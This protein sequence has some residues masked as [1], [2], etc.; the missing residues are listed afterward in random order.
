MI[1]FD[2]APLQS[3]QACEPIRRK[4]ATRLLSLPRRCANPSCS[5]TCSLCLPT[6]NQQRQLV[7]AQTSAVAAAAAAACVKVKPHVTKEKTLFEIIEPTS[8][9]TYSSNNQQIDVV[10]QASSSEELTELGKRGVISAIRIGEDVG[11]R[12]KFS[13][14]FD[15]IWSI[16]T[17][18]S[19]SPAYS[20]DQKNRGSFRWQVPV[21]TSGGVWCVELAVVRDDGVRYCSRSD[22]FVI[23]GRISDV[24]YCGGCRATT[25]T[26]LDRRQTFIQCLV[27]AAYWHLQCCNNA[28]TTTATQNNLEELQFECDT[29]R[30]MRFGFELVDENVAALQTF[31]SMLDSDFVGYSIRYVDQLA[32][33]PAAVVGLIVKCVQHACAGDSKGM[34]V[35]V[36]ISTITEIITN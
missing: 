28:T 10:W 35:I 6:I 33:T 19:S 21:G 9:D 27:C 1:C 16:C 32:R 18:L 15:S 14:E 24:T 8:T 13:D 26:M 3:S 36:E 11:R 34:I 22:A 12:Q 25:S 7:D 30:A 31:L 17:D 4:A 5:R 20:I 2:D 23:N 29:C